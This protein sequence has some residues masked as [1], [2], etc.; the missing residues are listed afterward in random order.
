[1]GPLTEAVTV[2][3]AC[4]YFADPSALGSTPRAAAGAVDVVD[5]VILCLV[6]N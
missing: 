6:K 3:P 1:M 2:Y 5:T 4:E